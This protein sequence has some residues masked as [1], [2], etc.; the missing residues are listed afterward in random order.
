MDD[1]FFIALKVFGGALG[2]VLFY[3]F[4]RFSL[5]K[6]F[7]LYVEKDPPKWMRY[8]ISEITQIL[9]FF[10]LMLVIYFVYR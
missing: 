4:G 7:K 8:F 6:I 9:I 2:A 5:S 3:K 10:G 1:V